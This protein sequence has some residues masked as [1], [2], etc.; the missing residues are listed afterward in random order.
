MP[1]LYWEKVAKEAADKRAR[2]LAD[3][4]SWR[5]STT[6]IES[7]GHKAGQPVSRRKGLTEHYWCPAC[8]KRQAE[9]K[10]AKSRAQ[11]VRCRECGLAIYPVKQ[12]ASSGKERRQCNG[13]EAPLRVNSIAS[14]CSLCES[15]FEGQ[16]PWRRW[17]APLEKKRHMFQDSPLRC[18][19]C[20]ANIGKLAERAEKKGEAPD[21]KG[22]SK[23]FE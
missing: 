17:K 23:F 3:R 22:F 9:T 15:R 4:A 19:Y 11:R 20:K 1:D 2:W 5:R 13:C 16:E 12:S 14:F 6:L 10:L 18:V 7:G 8:D 21:C